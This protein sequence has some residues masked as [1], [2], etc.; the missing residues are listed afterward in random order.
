MIL[1]KTFLKLMNKTVFARFREN[2]RKHRNITLATAE[3]TR[4]YL[5]CEPKQR[6]SVKKRETSTEEARYRQEEFNR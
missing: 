4:N 5:V 1:K 3:R 2:V 6:N